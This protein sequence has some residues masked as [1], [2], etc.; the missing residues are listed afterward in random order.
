V[1]TLAS[2]L[3]PH[4]E[5]LSSR[6]RVYADANLPAGLVAFMRQRLNWDVLFVV[7]HDELR[8]ARDIEH[9][10][11]ARK[12]RRTLVTLDRDYLDD[13]Q[14]PPHESPGVVVVSAPHERDL[15]RVLR[16]IDRALFGP[17]GA[18]RTESAGLPLEGHK[19]YAQADW[20]PQA[21]G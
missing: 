4:A 12:L 15:A 13:S 16:R 2:E 10:R 17:E 14:F 11:L 8:R 21:N 7:E 18:G 19:L 6:P 5:R 20:K 9:Y 1:R 3:A